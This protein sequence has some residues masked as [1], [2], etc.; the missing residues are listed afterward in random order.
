M[1]FLILGCNGMAG[2]TI[3][4]YLS[5]KGHDVTGYAR[6]QSKIV[7]T[8]IGDAFDQEY[9]KSIVV[10]GKFDS[11][12]NCIGILNRE[13]DIHKCQAVYLNAFLP[14]FLE[15]ITS[16]TGIQI[17]HISTDCVFSGK[18]G[19]YTE[20]ALRDGELFYDRSKALGELENNK[21]FTIRTSIIG[22][23]LNPNGIGLLNWFLMKKDVVCGYRKVMWTGM[24]TLQLAKC[25]ER[26][27]LEHLNGLY[28]MVPELSISKYDL[29]VLCNK[30]IR[31][32]ML[33]INGQ[34]TPKLD[35]SLIRSRKEFDYCVPDYHEMIKE[36]GI[37]MR[38]Y[39]D[40]Y[41]HYDL[42]EES[43]GVHR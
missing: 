13:A 40:L 39:R 3:S 38:K 26:I 12:V 36:L 2:H 22:P 18:K 17:I 28:N 29:L 7:K 25:V 5:S 42:P 20:N 32:D 27:S 14:H 11:V 6:K 34:D 4:L 24:T 9:L 15:D 16:E 21:D 19:H 31:K 10:G 23:D 30:I 8:V 35:K 43:G 41:P 1:R 33:I 37:W